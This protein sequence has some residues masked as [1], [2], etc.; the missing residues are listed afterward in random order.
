[1][2][3][4]QRRVKPRRAWVAAVLFLI[5]PGLG[6]LYAGRPKRG[7]AI[8]AGGI[9]L[10]VLFL[11]SGALRHFAGLVAFVLTLLLFAVWVIADAVSATLCPGEA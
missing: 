8:Y 4:E 9:A 2:D 7:L 3:I 6:Q 10:I 1:M 11:L 5:A